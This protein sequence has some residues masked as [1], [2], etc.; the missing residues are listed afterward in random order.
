MKPKLKDV[1]KAH[2]ECVDLRWKRRKTI[3]YKS[4]DICLYAVEKYIDIY[5]GFE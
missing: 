2:E 1:K 5:E 3:P 4:L